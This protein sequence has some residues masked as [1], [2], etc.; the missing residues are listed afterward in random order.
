MIQLEVQGHTLV[1]IL[2]RPAVRNAWN[3]ELAQGLHDAWRRLEADPELW[4]CVVTGNGGFF[5]S[6]MD[7][8]HPPMDLATLAMPNLSVP[9]DKPVICA[10]EGGAIGYAAVFCLLA[11]MVIAGE[12]AYFLYPEAKLGLFQGMMGGFP[13]RLQ[14][15]AGLQWLMTGEPMAAG[16]AREIGL[17]NEV[18]PDGNAA[19][20]ALHLAELINR[21]APLV[22]QAMKAFAL[23]TVPKGPMEAN[24]RTNRLLARIAAS[25]DGKEGIASFREKRHARFNGR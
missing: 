11:D 14:Y 23:S 24:Y 12:T 21:N 3:P 17:V 1:V 16:R 5:S 7:L 13:G 2:D 6:G 15:K 18:V 20:R 9:C 22:V 19:T 8:K 4:C 25:D 10:V